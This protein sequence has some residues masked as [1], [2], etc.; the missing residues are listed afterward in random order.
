[1]YDVGG[2]APGG[3]APM[4]M[5]CYGEALRFPGIKIVDR[6]RVIDD[7]FRLIETNF[8]IPMAVLNDIRCLIAACNR[9]DE[10][11]SEL[12]GS[13]GSTPTAA[14]SPPARTWPRRPCGPGSPRCPTAR[15]R[16]RSTSSTTAM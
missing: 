12:I 10:R 16:P 4:A 11:F 13:Y 14:T 3:F 6:G 5:E 9:C 15:S 2:M 7:V 8:R 1:M